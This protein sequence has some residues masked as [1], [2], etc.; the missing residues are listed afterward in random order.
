MLLDPYVAFNVIVPISLNGNATCIRAQNAE[1]GRQDMHKRTAE[2]DGPSTMD[3][4][5]ITTSKVIMMVTLLENVKTPISLRIYIR[6]IDSIMKLLSS[7]FPTTLTNM[8]FLHFIRTFEFLPPSTT[9]EPTMI[10]IFFNFY[11][12]PLLM[13]HP[14]WY[15]PDADLFISIK[16]SLY[17]LHQRRFE[18]SVFCNEILRYGKFNKIGTIPAHPIPFDAL[19]NDIFEKFLL[20]LY[21]SFPSEIS[22][23]FYELINLKVLS[24]DWYFPHQMAIIVRKL[25]ILRQQS[26]PPFHR[27]LLQ[28]FNAQHVARQQE[29]RWRETRRRTII[30]EESS[31]EE[32]TVVG[33][34]ST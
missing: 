6:I 24:I 8:S 5:D 31:D 16:G 32:E 9:L 14:V 3:Y 26:L 10:P 18:T 33:D 28:S 19:R 12:P 22:F 34:N 29:Y 13:K 4:V 2:K 21:S 20:L 1:K 15:Y 27:F 7:L 23:T 17:G 30:V 11:P 25:F